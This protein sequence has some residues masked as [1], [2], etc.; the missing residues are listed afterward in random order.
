[1]IDARWI[2]LLAVATGAAGCATAIRGTT[3]IVSITSDP[4]GAQ[5]MLLRDGVEAAQLAATPGRVTIGRGAADLV[6]HCRKAGYH[7]GRTLLIAGNRES[8]FVEAVRDDAE[9]RG[10]QGAG[11]REGAAAVA[12]GAAIAGTAAGTT[13]LIG[14]G[15]AGSTAAAGVLLVA[16]PVVLVAA[17]ISMAA[18]A[19]SGTY[20]A[21]PRSAA[22]VLLPYAFADSHARAEAIARVSAALD[23]DEQD[24]RRRF[25]DTCGLTCKRAKPAFEA[26]L[27]ERRAEFV[28]W[29]ALQR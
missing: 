24:L 22:V 10:G 14:A 17:P 5:C 11:A 26:F 29:Q 21:Y 23:S 18:D 12:G 28:R 2:L 8:M 13:A 6:V 25:D 27:D 20:Y 4:S 15:I 9:A 1:M 19:S 3:Q 16:A 7:D